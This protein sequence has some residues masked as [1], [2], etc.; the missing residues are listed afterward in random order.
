MVC[1]VGCDETKE[2]RNRADSV[3]LGEKQGRVAAQAI[4]SKAEAPDCVGR[5]GER[6]VGG[7]RARRR[8]VIK[9]ESHSAPNRFSCAGAEP[10]ATS[11]KLTLIQYGRRRSCSVRIFCTCFAHAEPA[12][13]ALARP[14]RTPQA[15]LRPPSRFSISQTQPTHS[16][17]APPPPPPPVHASLQPPAKLNSLWPSAQHTVPATLPISDLRRRKSKKEKKKKIFIEQKNKQMQ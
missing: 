15:Q 7:R 4:D 17:A 9:G 16:A 14:L 10:I 6:R 3:E 12:I 8:V 11:F 2:K 1:Q 13:Y 5:G